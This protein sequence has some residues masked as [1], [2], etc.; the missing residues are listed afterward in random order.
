MIGNQI[1]FVDD[2]ANVL[3][4]YRRSLHKRYQ[5]T[6]CLSGDEGLT[7]LATEGPFAVVVA[8]MQMPAH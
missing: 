2:D 5:I 7:K 4:A 3:S 6:T 8:D 1:L